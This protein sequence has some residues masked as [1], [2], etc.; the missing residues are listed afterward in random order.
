MRALVSCAGA[1]LVLALSLSFASCGDQTNDGHD[2]GAGD[3]LAASTGD[4]SGAADLAPP[5]DLEC[6]GPE[7][8]V[9][10]GLVSTEQRIECR[11]GCVI[12]RFANNVISG[13]WGTPIIETAVLT[14][15]LDGLVAQVMPSDGGAGVAALSSSAGAIPFFLD[16]DFDL[17]VDYRLPD[18]IPPDAHAILR[19]SIGGTDVYTI[20]RE[21][22][23]DGEERYRATLGGIAPVTRPTTAHSGTLRLVRSGFTIRAEA[24]GQ[25]VTQFTGA[26][27]ARLPI[28][29]TLGLTE[30]GCAVAGGARPDGGACAA[31]VIWQNLRLASGTLVDRQ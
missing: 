29:V 10:F 24:D 21:R 27:R 19:V 20:E 11:C 22:G 2:L 30:A 3:D 5:A 6:A 23:L 14:P 13:F 15:T 28:L 18:E 17:A 4:L 7:Y 1:G 16:G 31:T 26:T 25:T 8:F 9:G 12:D